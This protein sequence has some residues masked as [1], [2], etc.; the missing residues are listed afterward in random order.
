MIMRRIVHKV[1]KVTWVSLS[2]YGT[3]KIVKYLS[4][5]LE[6]PPVPKKHHS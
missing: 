1:G 2:G 5:A 3:S 6:V 4:S